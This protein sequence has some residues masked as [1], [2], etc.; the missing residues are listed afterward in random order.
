[1]IPD[2]NIRQQYK[3]EVIRNNNDIYG[4]RLLWFM[5]YVY[6][7]LSKEYI[8][9]VHVLLLLLTECECFVST[10]LSTMLRGVHAILIN[11]QSQKTSGAIA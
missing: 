5:Y 8:L 1:M 7:Y 3:N 11:F 9:M 10:N 6:V 2:I 4:L